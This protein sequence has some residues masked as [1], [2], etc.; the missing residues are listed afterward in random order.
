VRRSRSQAS[1]AFRFVL[2]IGIVNLFADFTYE[3]GRSIV[4]PFLAVLGPGGFK[5]AYWI[6]VT[7]GALMAAGFA[8][9]ALVSYHFQRAASIPG[10]LVPVLYAV[11]MA[12][13]AVAALAFGR[14]LDRVGFATVY[15]AFFL[16]SFSAPFAFLGGF[17]LALAGM[18]LWGIGIGVQDSLLKAILAEVVPAG[19]RST[20]FGLFD[21]VF[22]AAWF[23]GSAAMGFLYDR[24]LPAV[25]AFSV[26]LQLSA[27]PVLFFARKRQNH[28]SR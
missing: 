8:D 17:G 25:V 13:G 5:G 18:I 1:S 19:K 9:F 26:I 6:Y 23:I 3:G 15:T 20:G 24:S 7:A 11:A 28:Q 27:L 21:S 2:L 16:A 14:L 4:G 10:Q 12:T 22:G